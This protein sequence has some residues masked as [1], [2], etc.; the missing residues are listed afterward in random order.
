MSEFRFRA[1]AALE[2]RRTQEHEAGLARARAEAAV[3]EAERVAAVADGVRRTAQQRLQILERHG[4][5]VAT[6]MWHRNWI[7]RLTNDLAAKRHEVVMLAE[8]V[9]QAEQ[10]WRQARQRRLALERMQERAFRRFRAEQLRQELKVIDE[11]ARLRYVMADASGD[12]R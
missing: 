2:L 5:D 10:R 6:F 9:R 11:L 8:A 7:V 3:R 12:D 1:A 4:S